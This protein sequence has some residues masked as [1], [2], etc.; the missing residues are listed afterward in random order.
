MEITAIVGIVAAVL[1]IPLLLFGLMSFGLTQAVNTMSGRTFRILPA[2]ERKDR[3]KYR[4]AAEHHDWAASEGFEW[5]DGFRITQPQEIFIAAWK[6]NRLPRFFCV[7]ST[8]GKTHYDFVTLFA[9]DESLTTS[10]TKDAHTL[11]Q[12][13]GHWTQSFHGA[14]HEELWQRHREAE[15][16]LKDAEGVRPRQNLPPFEKILA[17]AIRNQMNHVKSIPLWQIRGVFWYLTRGGKTNR[18][19]ASQ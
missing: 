18:P 12:P 11:P 17:D 3:A 6:H 13:D 16:Y 7:Y 14:D 2:D 8:Q 15:A 5:I 4:D 19:I 1:V 9:E 10:G